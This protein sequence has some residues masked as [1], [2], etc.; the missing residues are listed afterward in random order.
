MKQLVRMPLFYVAIIAIIE[1]IVICVLIGLC[2]KW[3]G[4][5]NKLTK[6]EEETGKDGKTT[7]KEAGKE[8]Y[9]ARRCKNCKTN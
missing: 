6:P 7:G 3:K 5:L 9:G 8:S 2:A 4:E 1:L